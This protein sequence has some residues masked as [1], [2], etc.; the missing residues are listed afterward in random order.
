MKTYY[1]IED[2]TGAGFWDAVARRFGEYLF[3]HKFES[4]SEAFIFAEK[5]VRGV[6]KITKIYDIK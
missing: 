4:E 1:L 2:I 6:F 5:E 3:T